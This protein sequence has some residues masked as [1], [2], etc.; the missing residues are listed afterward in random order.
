MDYLITYDGWICFLELQKLNQCITNLGSTR[1]LFNL[2]LIVFSH[3][4]IGW[5]EGE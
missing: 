1:I 5:L 3:I 4:H 2:N